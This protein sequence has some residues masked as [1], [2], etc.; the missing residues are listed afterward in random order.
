[1]ASQFR[2]NSVPNSYEAH[3]QVIFFL[4]QRRRAVVIEWSWSRTRGRRCR[5]M[6]S[7]PIA[8]LKTLKSVEVSSDGLM[9]TFSEGMPDQVS[10]SL[11]Y[12]VHR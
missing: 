3:I 4:M 8:P 5:I 1:M 10:S 6:D 11:L 2:E 12:E 7:K 9:W